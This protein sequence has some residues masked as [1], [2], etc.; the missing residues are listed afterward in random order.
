[1]SSNNDLY[2][3]SYNGNGV[4]QYSAASGYTTRKLIDNQ[5]GN[6]RVAVNGVKDIVYIGNGGTLKA[7]NTNTGALI[8]TMT[9]LRRHQRNH[10]R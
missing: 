4:W 9:N 1:M 3:A 2:P 6:E 5:G 10:A 7:F 8:E